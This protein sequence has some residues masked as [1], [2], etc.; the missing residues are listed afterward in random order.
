MQSQPGCGAVQGTGGNSGVSFGGGGTWSEER[1]L[2]RMSF[3]RAFGV[4]K[5]VRVHLGGGEKPGRGQLEGE[6]ETERKD[7]PCERFLPQP[8]GRCFLIASDR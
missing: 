5:E 2:H 8:V 4:A 7:L 3:A 1:A 6:E